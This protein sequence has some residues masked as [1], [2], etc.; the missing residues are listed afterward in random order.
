[1][2]LLCTFSALCAVAVLVC[3]PSLCGS[4]SLRVALRALCGVFC[5][6]VGVFLAIG[7]R[8]ERVPGVV[9]RFRGAWG[10]LF[11]LSYMY[12]EPR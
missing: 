1:M 10:G 7:G 11:V 8:F 12:G 9:R 3:S 2:L 5:P 4:V 6:C